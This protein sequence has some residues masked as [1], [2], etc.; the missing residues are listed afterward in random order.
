M[1]RLHSSPLVGALTF[2]L[3]CTADTSSAQVG[4]TPHVRFDVP[5][6]ITA[7]EVDADGPYLGRLVEVTVPVSVRVVK[8]SIGRVEEVAIEIDASTAGLAV[9]DFAPRTTLGSDVADPIQVTTTKEAARAVDASLG[10]QSPIPI[11]DVVA[12]IAPSISAG[13]KDR[14]VE[15][16][17]LARLAPKR[18]IAVSGTIAGGQGAFFQFRPSSQTTLEGQQALSIVFQ[19]PDDWQASELEV[20]CIA[21]GQRRILWFE[22]RETWGS[23]QAKVEVALAGAAP[24]SHAVAKEV[25]EE[26]RGKWLPVKVEK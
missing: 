7:L 1:S 17:T 8:G 19:V 3:L 11:G 10:G 20:R 5:H 16:K 12:Q 25:V 13:K 14:E 26:T 9:H 4:D 2:L 23:C 18:P 15:T 24:I 22:Q 21:R 6:R